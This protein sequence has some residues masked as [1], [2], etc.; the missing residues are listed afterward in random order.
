[1]L[2]SVV[3]SGSRENFFDRSASQVKPGRFAKVEQFMSSPVKLFRK[4]DEA[5]R[6]DFSR[7]L[8]NVST[9]PI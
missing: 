5:S 6:H 3:P 1:M 8:V 4:V 2:F 9:Y 7:H